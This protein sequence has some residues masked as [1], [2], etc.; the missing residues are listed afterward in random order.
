[1]ISLVSYIYVCDIS[2]MHIFRIHPL[3]EWTA[4]WLKAC[5]CFICLVIVKKDFFSISLIAR[6]LAE[7][8]KSI[9]IKTNSHEKNKGCLYVLL[10]NHSS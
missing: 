4:T 3:G 5:L 7:L 2:L 9:E 6:V 1:M 10:T 8:V